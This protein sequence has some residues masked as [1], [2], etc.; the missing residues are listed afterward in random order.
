[1]NQKSIYPFLEM[2]IDDHEYINFPVQEI[3]KELI[4]LCLSNY[5]FEYMLKQTHKKILNKYGIVYSHIYL[6]LIEIAFQDITDSVHKIDEEEYLNV[7]Y[8]F[9]ELLESVKI[10]RVQKNSP[11]WEVI[12]AMQ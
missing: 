12:S 2:I 1:M 8:S 6:N 3:R 4:Q 5:E 9:I 7:M 11:D 10:T